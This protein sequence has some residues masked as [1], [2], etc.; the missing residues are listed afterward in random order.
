MRLPP[1]PSTLPSQSESSLQMTLRAYIGMLRMEDTVYG[2]EYFSKV[3]EKS[4]ERG[5][6]VG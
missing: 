3:R 2:N 6:S 1:P 4:Q 5:P